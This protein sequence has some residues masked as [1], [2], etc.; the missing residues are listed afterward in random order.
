MFVRPA[1]LVS[2]SLL[3]RLVPQER[4]TPVRRDDVFEAQKVRAAAPAG[5]NSSTALRSA[6]L[7]R[8]AYADEAT[9]RRE[10]EAQG[11]DLSTFTFL[12]DPSNDVQGFVVAGPDGSVYT[13][14]RGT[15]SAVDALVDARLCLKAPAWAPDVQVHDG[16]LRAVDAAWPEVQAAIEKAGS[17]P[18]VFTGHSLGGGLAQLAALRASREGLRDGVQVYTIGAPRSGDGAFAAA[19]AAELPRTYRMVNFD[20]GGID[21]Q[22]VIT[23]LPYE[24]CGFRHV[25]HEV[26]LIAPGGRADD[27]RDF[28]VGSVLLHDRG[29]YVRRLRALR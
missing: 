15:A 10:L 4:M 20:E 21:R 16:M 22:D 24:H 18:V 9:I 29:E 5:F 8:L 23:R 12:D 11:Y 3:R 13:A 25:G 19:F 17:G 27:G 6:E 1:P 2:L 14:F 28:V 7:S 26:R